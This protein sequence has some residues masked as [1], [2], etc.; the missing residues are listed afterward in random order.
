MSHDAVWEESPRSPETPAEAH[1]RGL[2]LSRDKQKGRST[3]SLSSSVFS[4]LSLNVAQCG[5]LVL[6]AVVLL[7]FKR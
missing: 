5:G 2:R 4:Y 1:T 6:S 7:L 3:L